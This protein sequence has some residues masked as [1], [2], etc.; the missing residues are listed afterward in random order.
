M[1]YPQVASETTSTDDST[2]NH[3]VSLPANIS[4][5]DLLII[6]FGTNLATTTTFPEGWTEFF[7]DASQTTVSLAIGW[8]KADGEEGASVEL[9]T[10]VTTYSA[11]YTVRITGA[12]DPE[13]QPP[14]VSA[15]STGYSDETECNALSP[16]GGAKDY[17]WLQVESN[18]DDD[19]VTGYPTGYVDTGFV[20]TAGNTL[21][22][23][24]DEITTDA[25]GGSSENFDLA[26]AEGWVHVVVA[27]HPSTASGTNTQI[28]IGDA[29]K[30]VAAMQ[31]N[32]SG[33]WKAVAAAQINISGAWHSI[34]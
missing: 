32:I 6:F 22:Y 8:R 10:N 27:V 26:A 29:W 33:A 13:T 15:A 9:T 17:L 3:T 21:G 30:D 11:H 4:S 7:D 24:R 28:N 34:F 31:I 19:D 2:T 23:C 12:E 25:Q 18:D 14:E 20:Q 1:A 5:G 16:T